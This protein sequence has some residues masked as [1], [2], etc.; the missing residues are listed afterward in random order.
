MVCTPPR[1]AN[2]YLYFFYLCDLHQ[3]I[4]TNIS[5]SV[6]TNP[7]TPFFTSL[8]MVIMELDGFQSLHQQCLILYSALLYSG[9]WEHEDQRPKQCKHK[10]DQALWMTFTH[11]LWSFKI[12]AL[13]LFP[14]HRVLRLKSSRQWAV[15][16]DKASSPQPPPSRISRQHTTSNGHRRDERIFCLVCRQCSLL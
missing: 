12:T 13:P 5:L 8:Y 7:D 6:L 11:S 9:G 2:T 3:D 14:C 16:S 4:C 10:W 1:N 15:S